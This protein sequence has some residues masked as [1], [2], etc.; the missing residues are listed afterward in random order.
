MA[1]LIEVNRGDDSEQCAQECLSKTLP[2]SWIVTTNVDERNFEG[3]HL[4]RKPEIDSI[5]ITPVGLFV[6]E[7]KA[8]RG[9]IIPSQN[10]PWMR[11]GLPVDGGK[12][13][14]DQR[15][16][17]IFALKTLLQSKLD[18]RPPWI[19]GLIVFTRPD[20]DLNWDESDVDN[21]EL[22][23]QAVPIANV[24]SSIQEIASGKGLSLEV[25]RDVVKALKPAKVPLDLFDSWSDTVSTPSKTLLGQ[26][27]RHATGEREV[28]TRRKRSDDEAEYFE[29][30]N[31][32][33]TTIEREPQTDNPAQNLLSRRVGFLGIAVAGIAAWQL[34]Y[35]SSTNIDARR[36]ERVRIETIREQKEQKQREELRRQDEQRQRTE[37]RRQ[38][39][40]QM[41]RA[42]LQRQ[43]QEYE[44]R[45]TM[46]ADGIRAGRC[47]G[48]PRGAYWCC[49]PGMWA[50]PGGGCSRS[51]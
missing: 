7:L 30:G 23:L 12:N 8:H 15:R 44:R 51:R 16:T 43:Q 3:L 14:F 6:L 32:A 2:S 5:L 18:Q 42:E 46:I 40:E 31:D 13:F 25:A 37:Q 35:N 17:N 48:N 10:G 28:G 41:Q 22:R 11:D 4:N 9:A 49:D 26:Q 34:W 33:K 36:D 38:R 21:N 45:A 20:V 50:R 1:R 29:R 39:D 27:D 47:G 24:E 19:E